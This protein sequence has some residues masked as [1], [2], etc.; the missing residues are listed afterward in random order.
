MLEAAFD[1]PSVESGG[2]DTIFQSAGLT[3]L[4][5]TL[6]RA[7]GLAFSFTR[8]EADPEVARRDLALA[9]EALASRPELDAALEAATARLAMGADADG[10]AEQMRLIAARAESDRALAALSSDEDD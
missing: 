2:V 8:G 10:F 9:I 4:V 1:A 5:E 3:T 7:N 6:R